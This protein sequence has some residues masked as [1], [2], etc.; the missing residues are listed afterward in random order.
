MT[1]WGHVILY[2]SRWRQRTERAAR[3]T[4]PDKNCLRTCLQLFFSSLRDNRDE[5]KTQ[6]PLPPLLHATYRLPNH[7]AHRT[8]RNT[9]YV[10]NRDNR[11]L[12]AVH[13]GTNSKKGLMIFTS[14]SRKERVEPTLNDSTS[15]K[16]SFNGKPWSRKG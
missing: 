4:D 14:G 8:H 9:K 15:D 3:T 6:T 11:R 12:S 1:S 16:A 10:P 7:T 13:R 5:T 2:S